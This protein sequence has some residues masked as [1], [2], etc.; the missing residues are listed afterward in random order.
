MDEVRGLQSGL[1]FIAWIRVQIRKEGPLGV[2]RGR[3]AQKYGSNAEAQEEVDDRKVWL[4][5]W[6]LIRSVTTS[7]STGSPPISNAHLCVTGTFLGGPN[8]VCDIPT[9]TWI[10]FFLVVQMIACMLMIRVR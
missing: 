10:R 1:S 7:A 2:L 3:G 6:V 5:L 4:I 8:A 9:S